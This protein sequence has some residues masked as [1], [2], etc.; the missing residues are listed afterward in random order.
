MANAPSHEQA[1]PGSSR[2]NEPKTFPREN[3]QSRLTW[4]LQRN[5]SPSRRTHPTRRPEATNPG[6]SRG[7]EAH[8]GRGNE[9]SKD[10]GGQRLVAPVLP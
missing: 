9:R 10:S 8:I 7:N 6:S 2:G 5:F 4:L 3:S 1:A